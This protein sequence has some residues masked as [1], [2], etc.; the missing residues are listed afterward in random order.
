MAR[1][2][3]HGAY[4]TIEHG[5][6]DKA[7]LVSAIR[8]FGKVQGFGPMLGLNMQCFPTGQGRFGL[9]RD[10]PRF[11]SESQDARA[12]NGWNGAAG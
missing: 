10:F 3:G 9:W 6:L 11:L 7:G 5:G 8:R 12:M 1:I 2:R 4:V